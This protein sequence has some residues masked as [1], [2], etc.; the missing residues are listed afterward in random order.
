[1]KRPVVWFSLAWVLGVCLALNYELHISIMVWTGLSLFLVL[2]TTLTQI[3]YK[4]WMVC[5]S[6]LAVSLFYCYWVEERNKSQI[7]AESLGMSEKDSHLLAGSE[8]VINADIISSVEIDGDRVSFVVKVRQL[9]LGE[10]IGSGSEPIGSGSEPV[11]PDSESRGHSNTYSEKIQVSIKLLT[12]EE[13][14]KAKSW[15]RNDTISLSGALIEPSPARNFGGFDY[16]RYLLFRHIH[17]MVQTKGLE[18]IEVKSAFRWNLNQLY[19]WNDKLRD[20]LGSKLEAIYSAEQTGFMKSL[21]LGI[22][23]DL[24]PGQFQQFSQIGLTHVL[25]ISGLHVAVFLASCIG[26]MRAF[27]ITRET[28]LLVAMLL[29]PAY[30][31]ITGSSPSVVRAGT[32][33]MIALYAARKRLLK[34]GVH[35]V[36]IVGFLMLLWNP[37]LL[38]DVSFQ[39]S[40]LVTL[41]LIIGVPQISRLLPIQTKWINSSI[42][43]TLVAQVVSFPL[44]IYYFNQFSLLSWLANLFLVPLIS[45][46]VLPLGSIA[47]IISL[48]SES[49]AAWLAWITEWINSLIFLIVN[50]LNSL[51][52]FVMIWASPLIIWILLYYLLMVL[53]IKSLLIWTNKSEVEHIM[54]HSQRSKRPG[55]KTSLILLSSW[56]LLLWIGYHPNMGNKHQGEV[57]FIDVGQG[58]AI[59]IRTPENRYI[60]N[61]GGGTI[62]FRKRGDEWKNR[63]DPYEVGKKLLVPLLKKRGVQQIDYLIISHEHADHIGGLQAVLEQIPVRLVIFNGTLSPNE[64]TIKLFRTALDLHIPLIEAYAGERLQVDKHTSLQ[65]LY[66]FAEEERGD[67][68]EDKPVEEQTVDLN[69]AQNNVSVV[70]IM[71]MYD[72]TFLFTGD[73]EHKAEMDLLH[74]LE[75]EGNSGDGSS[76]GGNTKIDVLKAAHHGSKT[77]TSQEWLNFWRPGA[78]VISVG[79]YNSYGHPNPP[80]LERLSEQGIS[81]YRTDGH[82]EIQMKVKE[83]SLQVRT[84]M[85]NLVY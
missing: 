46:I 68:P 85:I 30:V 39:L 60:L 66:P 36:S 41:G 48:F 43:V 84:K 83:H 78:A 69:S 56:I 63:K 71:K 77:S 11:G 37:Y 65:F 33:G 64:Q 8:V 32:M 22:T 53:L 50:E 42:S 21:I 1:M 47:M 3:R 25:A 80:V 15:K 51:K 73:M 49:A 19:R 18:H 31:L 55:W 54:G 29:I 38:M 59:L 24:D 23:G 67:E 17:W 81:I 7:S 76:G 40:F 75:S 6:V 74:R 79:L 72:S 34:D 58:D 61:D 20:F 10:P 26:L 5:L 12:L 27:K 14:Q 82:G 16:K 70:F 9:S 52:I 44:S 62:T 45:F 2:A 4:S 35:I 13:L 57:Q 28:N